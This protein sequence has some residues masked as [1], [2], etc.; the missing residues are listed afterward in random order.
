MSNLSTRTNTQLCLAPSASA[1][2]SSDWNGEDGDYDGY[3]PIHVNNHS[4]GR[5]YFD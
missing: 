3:L 2:D 4:I 1:V 5:M